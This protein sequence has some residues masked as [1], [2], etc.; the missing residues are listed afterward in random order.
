MYICPSCGE[1]FEGNVCPSCCTMRP[2]AAVIGKSGSILK[3]P[4]NSAAA[5]GQHAVQLVQE[6]EYSRAMAEQWKEEQRRLDE[7]ERQENERRAHEE[8][9]ARNAEKAR[10]WK[11]KAPGMRAQIIEE[12]DDQSVQVTDALRSLKIAPEKPV[13]KPEQPKKSA[14]SQWVKQT[15]AA[16]SAAK[17]GDRGKSSKRSTPNAQRIDDAWRTFARDRKDADK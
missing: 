16:P 2:S 1:P 4:A 10:S 6:L 5:P 14:V 3:K 11:R 15:N 17:A 13:V 9:L 12:E 8:R 7:L